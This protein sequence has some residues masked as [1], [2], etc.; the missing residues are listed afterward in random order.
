MAKRIHKTKCIPDSIIC[1][2]LLYP[3]QGHIKQSIPPP[4]RNKFF[5]LV[6]PIYKMLF[7]LISV[8]MLGFFR[9]FFIDKIQTVL[10][11]T[12]IL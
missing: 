12:K 2:P 1:L 7:C 10:C 11:I 4:G 3:I 6:I 8:V 9:W 5:I